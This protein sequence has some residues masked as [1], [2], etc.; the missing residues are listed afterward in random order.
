[1]FLQ[2]SPSCIEQRDVVSRQWPVH[3]ARLHYLL[4]WIADH[5]GGFGLTVAVADGQVPGPANTFY[6]LVIQWFAG[7]YHFAQSHGIAFQPLLRE[8]APDGRRSAQGCDAESNQ[9]FRCVARA[10]ARLAIYEYRR[11]RIPGR[12]DGT[13]GVFGPS[14]R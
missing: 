9:G 10:E 3:T 12:Q 1:P 5:S 8:Q 13:P 2:C 6:H 11:A 4:R 14:R 7:A